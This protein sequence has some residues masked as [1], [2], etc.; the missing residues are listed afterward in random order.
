MQNKT[1]KSNK[2]HIDNFIGFCVQNDKFENY[3]F[4][5]TSELQKNI[6]IA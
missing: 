5:P 3:K 1:V 2:I 4:K 6:K